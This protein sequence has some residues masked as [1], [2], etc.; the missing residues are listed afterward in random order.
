MGTGDGTD[1]A[2]ARFAALVSSPPDAVAGSLAEG[3]L[4]IA[5]HANRGVDVDAYL[6]VLAG[7]ADGC[8]AGDVDAVV[9]RL[10]DVE[11]FTGNAVDYYAA[12]NSYLD[13]VIDRRLGIPITLAVVLLDVGRRCGLSLAGVGMPGHFLVRL[14]DD[15]PR[16]LDPFERGRTLTVDDCVA[17]FH[18]TQG[19]EAA[20]D[21]SYLDPVDA[22]TIL[23]RILGNLRGIHMANRDSRGLEWVLRLR[24]LL[25][26]ATIRDRAERAGVLA[27]M[28]RYGEAATVLDDLVPEATGTMVDQLATQAKKLRARL[29]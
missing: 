23:G 1:D 12:E 28:G 26:G 5:A 27:A 11:G 25:P 2:T 15:R 8:P 3:A 17:R 20:F 13:R 29:N 6:D 18:A 21:I 7:F 16:F 14:D 9:H 4:L 24:G 19:A 10:Y 22:P